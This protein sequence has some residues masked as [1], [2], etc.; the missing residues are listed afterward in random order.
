VRTMFIGEA[1]KKDPTLAY[2]RSAASGVR[3]HESAIKIQREQIMDELIGGK[4][5]NL[6]GGYSLASSMGFTGT[7]FTVSGSGNEMIMREAFNE[8]EGIPGKEIKMHITF[9]GHDGT[10]Q[11]IRYEQNGKQVFV[12]MEEDYSTFP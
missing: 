12:K 8:V 3:T 5:T 7:D 6:K 9:G 10:Q 1:I 2:S 4:K 11:I